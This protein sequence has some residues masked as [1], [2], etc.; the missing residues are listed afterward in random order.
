MAIFA[1]IALGLLAFGGV[2]RGFTAITADGV[3]RID[4][5][6]AP[7]TLPVLSMID[8]TGENPVAGRLWQRVRLYD[9]CHVAL[10]QLRHHLPYKCIGTGVFVAGSTEPG[11]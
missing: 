10:H 7:R 3:R 1:L 8:Q 9:L 5:E 2:T 4:L 11:P 6:H